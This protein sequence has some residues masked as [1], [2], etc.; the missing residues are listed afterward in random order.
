V[1]AVE[2]RKKPTRQIAERAAQQLREF[3]GARTEKS[4]GAEAHQAEFL[5]RRPASGPSVQSHLYFEIVGPVSA[6]YRAALVAEFEHCLL[7]A[8]EAGPAFAMLTEHD[9]LPTMHW[10]LDLPA[11]VRV[12]IHTTGGAKLWA[13]EHLVQTCFEKAAEGCVV[14]AE[15]P[16]VPP[17]SPSR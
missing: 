10:S 12:D 3:L 16:A 13:F 7:K 15:A 14:E 8:R 1:L 5:Y 4:P 6:G 2:R 9:R 17:T 11:R